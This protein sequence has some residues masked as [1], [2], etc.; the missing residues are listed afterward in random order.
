VNKPAPLQSLDDFL[1]LLKGVKAMPNGQ[2]MALCPGHNDRQRSL[3]ITEADG[4]IL[5]HCFAG[6]QLAEILKPLGLQSQDLFLNGNHNIRAGNRIIE[7][8]YDYTD[9]SGKMLF[10]VVR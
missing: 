3:S 7:T 4:M 1:L 5:P 10:Q 6:C 8:T 2:F 9:T